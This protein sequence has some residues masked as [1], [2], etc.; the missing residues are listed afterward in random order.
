MRPMP[1]GWW[2][3]LG[4]QLVAEGGAPETGQQFEVLPRRWV[5]ERTWPGS[6]G[7]D[8]SARIRGTACRPGFI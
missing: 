1:V 3:G 4:R 6:A 5:V 2:R 7:A 8:G